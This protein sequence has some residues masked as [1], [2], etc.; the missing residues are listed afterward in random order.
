MCK[1]YIIL[2]ILNLR[3]TAYSCG[4]VPVWHTKFFKKGN[5]LVCLDTVSSS[6]KEGSVNISSQSIVKDNKY[7]KLKFVTPI[8]SPVMKN[9]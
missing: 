8:A 7:V 1:Y 5:K 4:S 9:V 6:G 2:F 3:L